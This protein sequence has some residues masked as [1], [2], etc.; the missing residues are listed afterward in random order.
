MAGPLNVSYS[1][2][3]S[4]IL[5]PGHLR[6]QLITSYWI[7]SYW[8]W[9]VDQSDSTLPG[10]N[11]ALNS[12]VRTSTNTFFFLSFSLYGVP[13]STFVF[14]FG[15][16]FASKAGSHSGVPVLGRPALLAEDKGSVNIVP[17]NCERL[18]L[19]LV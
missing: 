1:L 14:R 3:I 19:S 6:G 2:I 17:I 11:K 5:C 10:M 4:Y 13:S 8:H 16:D 9:A 18:S 12:I 15:L 7:S